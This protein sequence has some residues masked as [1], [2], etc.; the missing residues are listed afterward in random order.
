[1]NNTIGKP[2]LEIF[3]DTLLNEAKK[4]K[5]I[6]VVT[7]DSRGS[8]KLVNFGKELPSQLIEVGIAEQNLVAVCAGLSAGGKKVFGVSPASFLTA[9]SLEQIKNDIAYSNRPAVMV[10]ISAGISYGQLGAT[11]HSIHDY[12]TLRTI[13]NMTIVSPAD[14]F[15]ASEVIKQSINYEKPLYIRYGKK[16]L[17]NLY[18]KEQNFKI[19]K[20]NILKKGSDLVFI[21]T[22]ETVQRAYLSSQLLEKEGIQSTV[23]SMH[24]L[25]PF[26][27]ETFL[28]AILNQKVLISLEEHSVYG[29]LG[30][31]CASVITQ[32]KININYKILGIPDEYMVNGSQSDVLDH[33]G[34]SPE[35]LTNLAKSMI[36]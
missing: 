29:G 32:E 14:N 15:E 34:M 8:G 30:E 28:E 12:A 13:N 22:G 26:D 35:K 19:G 17:L 5:N 3:A 33:Y 27:K 4:N 18:S 20:A 1:M 6:I 2:N 7:S 9:R 21:A 24:T 11:H 36:E 16:P 10:G 23:V 25:K 31:M